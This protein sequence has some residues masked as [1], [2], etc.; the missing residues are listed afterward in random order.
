MNINLYN[1]EIK[2]Y[3]NSLGVQ[4]VRTLRIDKELYM[5]GLKISQKQI[6]TDADIDGSHIRNFDFDP[7]FR[8]MKALI[9]NGLRLYSPCLLCIFWRER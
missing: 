1:E 2:E 7:F 3:F 9:E 5:Y 4:N 8:Y 6:M